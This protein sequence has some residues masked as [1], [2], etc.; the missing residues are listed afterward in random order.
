MKIFT[1]E[2]EV[3][4]NDFRLERFGR[5][6]ERVEARLS[7]DETAE[8]V[9]ELKLEIARLQG[10]L[11]RSEALVSR[12]RAETQHRIR[13]L[14]TVIRSI[15]TRSFERA[16]SLEDL[17]HHQS[18][19]ISALAR[20]EEGLDAFAGEGA[21]LERLLWDEWLVVLSPT[22]EWRAEA[23]GPSVLLAPRAAERIG[24]ALHELTTNALKFG[25]LS[26]SQG[27][28]RVSWRIL[29]DVLEFAWSETDVP[30]MNM[31]PKREGFGRD[32]LERAL[33]YDL[34]AETRLSFS[35]GGVHCSIRLP[36]RNNVV[37][38]S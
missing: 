30:L 24:L 19:R 26:S 12:R 23:S 11:A 7:D 22:E 3:S 6:P 29:D 8:A 36:M 35:P 37:V 15:S 34:R 38:R 2:A 32:L 9:S 20:V 17:G 33:P 14:L 31:S 21:D 27:R 28:I 25:A 1:L 10:A 16:L 5:S 13:N 4:S 18:G